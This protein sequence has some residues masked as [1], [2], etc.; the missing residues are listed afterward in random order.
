MQFQEY[1]PTFG[2]ILS[3]CT[4]IV[5]R[6]RHLTN[7]D[8]INHTTWDKLSEWE[9]TVTYCRLFIA[10]FKHLQIKIH[11]RAKKEKIIYTN[12][13][14]LFLQTET[15]IKTLK[16]KTRKKLLTVLLNQDYCH[17]ILSL[18]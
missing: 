4:I 2:W 16:E 3:N 1:V 13:K 5:R 14:Q 15:V 11:K 17:F 9:P 12:S 6:K 10:K 18:H 8:L 7:A